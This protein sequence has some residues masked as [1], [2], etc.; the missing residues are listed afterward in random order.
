MGVFM[1][2]LAGGG[3]LVLVGALLIAF[4]RRMRWISSAAC[5]RMQLCGELTLAA[6]AAYWLTGALI[7]QV[8]FGGLSSAAQAEGIFRGPY[9]QRV[10]S[11]LPQ[12]SLSDPLSGVF[13]WPAHL[14]GRILFEQYTFAGMT[15]SWMLV[16]AG[17]CLLQAGTER[18]LG[19]QWA[20]DVSVLFLCLPVSPFLFLPGWPCLLFPAAAGVFF[21]FSRRMKKRTPA[22]PGAW[23]AWALA[24]FMCLSG[25]ALACI[26]LGKL[27]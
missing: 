14:L 7:S 25:A 21:A 4:L 3:M 11:A 2:L 5:K 17:L 24:F 9:V 8:F 6:G 15:L 20:R 27:G 10:F 16:F 1:G 26:V 23:Y 18:W 19:G 22:P 12:P 13:A